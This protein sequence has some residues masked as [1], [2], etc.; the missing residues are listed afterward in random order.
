[1]HQFRRWIVGLGILV[2]LGGAGNKI[3]AENPEQIDVSKL[4]V[5]SIQEIDLMAGPGRT[6]AHLAPDGQHFAYISSGAVCLYTVSG[7]QQRCIDLSALGL[8][9]D[10]EQTQ[11]SPDSCH[12][13]LATD[14]LRTFRDPDIWVADLCTGTLANLTDDHF[15]GNPFDEE[16][17]QGFADLGARFIDEGE[18]LVF[19]RYRYGGDR[20]QIASIMSIKLDGTDLQTIGTIQ[21]QSQFSIFSFDQSPD[22]TQWAYNYFPND[23]DDPDSGTWIADAQFDQ[24]HHVGVFEYA[25]GNETL[26][27]P[28]WWVE[29]SPD[30]QYLMT[31]SDRALGQYIGSEGLLPAPQISPIRIFAVNDGQVFL[32]D[33]QYLVRGG[34]WA[35]SGHAFAYV[36]FDPQQEEGS[37]LYL[38]AGPG[39]PSRL[40][41][42]GMFLPP[43][44]RSHQ[45]L[46]WTSNNTLLFGTFPPEKIV[47]V[48]L[49]EGPSV[50]TE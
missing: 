10:T 30:G 2:L 7:E 37:G 48:Q 47:I 44:S 29:F 45:P 14:F 22:R 3:A 35:P 42:P 31:Y 26:T 6:S 41:L 4:N 12:L 17:E 8:P 18:R 46:T 23:L 34:T 49:G 38:S 32:P 39:E 19:G 5:I 24:P 36:V 13:T 33:E 15:A 50:S 21:T 40:V 16:A 9:L 43:T 1:M 27:S 20:P 28:A 25:S 11:W